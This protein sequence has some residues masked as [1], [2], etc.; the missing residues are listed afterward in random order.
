LHV[1]S[2]RPVLARLARTLRQRLILL[3]A[4]ALLPPTGVSL[5]FAWSAYSENVK[6]T[7]LSVRQLAI[8][9]A[10]FERKFFD[11]IRQALGRI[12]GELTS[13]EPAMRDCSARLAETLEESRKLAGLAIYDSGGALV[14][15]TER[16]LDDVSTEPWYQSARQSR[17]F[18]VSDYTHMPDSPYP[19]IVAAYPLHD[20]QGAAAG[21]LSASIELY[22]IS[23]FLS[24]VPL[25]PEGVFFLLDRE[26]NVLANSSLFLDNAN[27]A[28]PKEGGVLS[29]GDGLKPTVQGDVI[30]RVLSRQIIDFEAIG[31]DGVK[32][33]YASAAL[34]YGNVTLLFAVPSVSTLG[35][36]KQDFVARVLGL[37][38]IWIIGL[39][40]A[41]LG[42]RLLVTRWT[43]AL[44][45]VAL[46]YGRGDYSAK[47]DTRRAPTELRDLGD[48]LILMA[49]RI[50][51]RE[52]A[53]H[54]SLAQ[55]DILIKEIHHRVKNNMQ[56]VTSLINLHGKSVEG[57]NAREALQ[58]VKTRIRALAL[59]HRHLYEG[60]DV[61]VV[62]MSSFLGELCRTLV[63]S[64]TPADSRIAL[65]LDVPEIMILSDRAVPIALLTAEAVTNSLKHG[66]PNGRSGEISVT[67]E[68]DGSLYG[69]LVIAD[70]GAGL[71]PGVPEVERLGLRLIDAFAHQI[72]GELEISGPPGTV[73]RLR[74]RLGALAARRLDSPK[75]RSKSARIAAAL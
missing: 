59:V 1:P 52:E 56:I 6:Q 11:D 2:L 61:R 62:G 20:V 8:L 23:A 33:L 44:R 73:I 50:Q 72:G 3:F 39:G 22:W 57:P 10:S 35:W 67:F 28:L 40:T 71:P 19:V 47:L 5:Y 15:G 70:N 7:K 75:R 66:F 9:A 53:L 37:A 38:S 30:Q 18:T 34:P 29:S 46:A 69:V 64:L 58:E 27:P 24:E 68:Q 14:C 12:G 45:Q 43:T 41:A 36:I 16:S 54:Q 17:S 48:T 13:G 31:S 25:P 63:G 21:L 55:K 32:R 49:R 65:R 42:T 26:G 4:I 51:A 74:V 60:E